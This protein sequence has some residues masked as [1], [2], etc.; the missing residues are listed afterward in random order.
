MREVKTITIS[1]MGK[2]CL[3]KFGA[4]FLGHLRNY[5]SFSESM[6]SPSTDKWKFWFTVH[7]SVAETAYI[8]KYFIDGD[9]P[10]QVWS[11]MASIFL[12]F[13][14]QQFIC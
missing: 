9:N 8:A 13:T 5:N 4:L 1:P 2:S 12:L 10:S 14:T 3:G 6:L 7:H 11:F